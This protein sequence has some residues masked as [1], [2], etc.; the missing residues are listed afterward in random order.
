MEQLLYQLIQEIKKDH[1]V[2]V[3]APYCDEELKQ[4]GNV[5]RS[6][7]KG[8]I[9]FF[10]FVLSRGR[11][12]LNQFQPDLI[13]GGSAVVSPLVFL[14]SKRKNI[15]GA[16]YVHGLD[17][18][19]NHW[20]YQTV[21]RGLLPRLDFIIANSRQTK[22]NAI[23]RGVKEERVYILHPGIYTADYDLRFGRTEIRDR[24]QLDEKKVLFYAGRLA[25]RKGLLEFVENSL[26]NITAEFPD[27]VLLVVGDNPTS[28]LS[29]HEDLRKLVERKVQQL[30]LRKHVRF[31]GWVER[32]ILLEL[33]AAS[34]IF[35]LPAINVPGD[36]EGF[37]IV[38]AEANAA[39]IPAVST[40]TGGIPDAVENGRTA[41]L[42][43]P[44][45]WNAYSR[46]IISL[47][48]DDQLR[49]K[50][51]NAGFQRTRQELDWR[52]TS[53]KFRAILEENISSSI[54]TE[55]LS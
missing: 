43:E 39:G 46:A 50:M 52:V 3:L 14:F 26:P 21:I 51:G 20:I 32:K 12:I 5:L 41:L 11:Q 48:E 8:L 15:P 2:I 16:V 18:L 29:H 35:I 22:A 24:Y 42:T 33:Y 19:Y 10:F 44:G 38:L 7:G 30:G 40:N 37:G 54:S 9:R 31:F 23:L 36:M 47:L 25:R 13:L 4:E 1:E 55:Q 17:L 53:A 34:D 49:L 28:S 27:V 6:Q 45:D